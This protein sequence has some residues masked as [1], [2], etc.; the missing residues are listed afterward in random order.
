MM[1]DKLRTENVKDLF[2]AILTLQNV[3][4][5]YAFLKMFVP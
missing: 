4:E 5:C 3:D 2:E 1:A